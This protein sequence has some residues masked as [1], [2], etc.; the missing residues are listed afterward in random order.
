MPI[1]VDSLQTFGSP[2]FT[3]V[4][5]VQPTDII[6]GER[7]GAP[8]SMLADTLRSF[9]V[10][11][12]A[13]GSGVT[14]G[15]NAPDNASGNQGDIYIRTTGE[16]YSRS[17]STWDLQIDFV[18]QAELT[19]ALSAAITNHETA[20]DPHTVYLT[21]ARGDARYPLL[22]A[23]NE[24]I[25]D[26]VAALLL[27]GANIT[28]TYNDAANTFTVASTASGGGE[29]QGGLRYNFNAATTFPSATGQVRLN[30][31]TIAS[32]T[33]INI[34]ES[35]RNSAQQ[36]EILDVI[37]VGTRIQIAQEDNEEIYAWFRVS[38]ATV[39][40]G[41]DRTIPVTFV[42]ASGVLI[43]GE[44]TL[45]LLQIQGTASG[46]GASG[47]QYTY[48]ATAGT[49]VISAADLSTATTLT[50]GTPDA[51]GKVVSDVLA[52]LKAGA[53]IEIAKDAANRVR[54]SV[55]S[56]HTSGAV[57]V[58]LAAVYG[59]IASGDTVFLMIVSDAPN[60]VVGGTGRVTMTANRTYYVRSDGV[61]TG[62][63]AS[64]IDGTTNVPSDAFANINVAISAL[65]KID[66]NGF[67][68][69]LQVGPGTFEGQL[70]LFSIVG[71][72]FAYL[73]GEGVGSTTFSYTGALSGNG[74]DGAIQNKSVSTVWEVSEAKVTVTGAGERGGLVCGIGKLK[75]KNLQL[76]SSVFDVWL[77]GSG[78][79]EVTGNYS[80]SRNKD[81]HV[82][83]TG[84]ALFIAQGRT[85]TL[86]D[87][88]NF[89][90]AGI[91]CSYGSPQ[92]L[93]NL[94]TFAGSATGVRFNCV[95]GGRIIASLPNPGYLPGDTAGVS[96]P[97]GFYNAF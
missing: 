53:I 26:R 58:A 94:N 19:A 97:E 49:G 50:L 59:A 90:T 61:R 22:T 5:T 71:C 40:N 60:T 66:S 37:A 39:D 63:L 64:E 28:L 31:A 81:R 54:Y 23:L 33:Q 96:T 62:V 79:V 9:I 7:A 89:N 57:G 15:I 76:D 36:G 14:F 11:A 41:S 8:I 78:T 74:N 20:T 10:A 67:S 69:T 32:V 72:D 27:S 85:I 30:N 43:A 44:V 52:R 35:D 38:G 55:T 93:V 29:A 65:R 48:R 13:D 2:L 25:D 24:S 92:A 3:R 56:D 77:P 95:Y 91:L 16:I 17:A 82:Y 1:E 21:Q 86:I 46:S 84:T 87:A 6:P 45:N 80:I 4:G 12:I 75:F 68:P 70:E 18:S 42:S 73:R 88:P 83:M 34:H 47:I 51:Q